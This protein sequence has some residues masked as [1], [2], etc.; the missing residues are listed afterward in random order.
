M[1]DPKQ[2]KL[3]VPENGFNR[4]QQRG[5]TH[6]YKEWIKSNGKNK[7]THDE[8]TSVH[9]HLRIQIGI[10]TLTFFST[11]KKKRNSSVITKEG[12]KK[13][14]KFEINIAMGIGSTPNRTKIKT[15]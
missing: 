13:E 9:K 6:F 10:P 4:E 7:Q 2:T 11:R 1:H 8:T 5:Q 3:K 14:S 12:T 15:N